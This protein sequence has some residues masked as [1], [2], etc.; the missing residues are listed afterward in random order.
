MAKKKSEETQIGNYLIAEKPLEFIS[1]GCKI[2]DCTV[3][4][5][6]PLRRI[7]NIVGDKSS[8]KTGLVVEVMAN[9]RQ[10]YPQGYIW[11][12]EAESAFDLDYAHMLGMPDTLADG[13]KDPNIFLIEDVETI[14]GLKKTIYEAID[15]TAKDDIPG[16]YVLDT[17]DAIKLDQHE[18]NEGYDAARRAGLI[19]SL[20]T[21]LAGDIKRA[22]MHL[23]VVSQIR[24]NIG[25][26]LFSEKYR[27]SGGKALDFYASQVVWLAV[28]EKIKQ[29]I[30]GLTL[31]S[32]IW[33][34]G[35]VKKN[36]V[37]LPF[38][39]C[40]FPVIFNYGIHDV[41]ASLEWLKGIK[42]GLDSLGIS[43][44]EIKSYADT[45]RN[46]KDVETKAKI[47]DLVEKFWKEINDEFLPTIKKYN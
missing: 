29:V 21:N 12:H 8:N 44:K 28:T 19:N 35:S 26:G 34:K 33:V 32:G 9:F 7:S 1:T 25:A 45:I 27:R 15:K 23:L 16:L 38:R 47:D 42:G 14:E 41:W 6:L 43:S 5:G 30:Q 2:F 46:N 39:Q 24:E 37:G 20:I 3:G 13:T 4:G 36:K 22:N 17:L 11:Y 18:T 31:I 40:E 10:K